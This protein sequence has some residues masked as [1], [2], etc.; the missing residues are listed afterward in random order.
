[1]LSRIGKQ[2]QVEAVIKGSFL[3]VNDSLVIKV[4]LYNVDSGILMQEEKVS[5][6]SLEQIFGMV[7]ELSKSVKADLRLSFKEADEHDLSKAKQ[8][9]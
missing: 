1:M 7:D 6:Q 8:N 5:G 4:Q 3:N 2:A 9:I